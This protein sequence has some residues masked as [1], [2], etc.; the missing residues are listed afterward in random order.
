MVFVGAV[1]LG[2]N[3]HRGYAASIDE[4]RLRQL[5]AAFVL[6]FMKFTHWPDQDEHP[7]RVLV[8]NNNTFATTLGGLTHERHVQNRPVE[9]HTHPPLPTHDAHDDTWNTYLATATQFDVIYAHADR[10]AAF[11]R[12][13]RATTLQPILL[14]ADQPQGIA[15]GSML[16]LGLEEGKVVFHAGRRAIDTSP[17]TLRAQ[18]LKLARMHE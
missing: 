14:I 11:Q 18:L 8:L 2:V 15:H 13:A 10:G 12:L 1:F 5:Q 16:A 7:L 17:L 9:V 6:N 4:G 3:A